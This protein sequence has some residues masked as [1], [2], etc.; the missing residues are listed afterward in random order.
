MALL[1]AQFV[2]AVQPAPVGT[3]IHDWPGQNIPTGWISVDGQAISRDDYADLFSAI[4]T[5]YGVGD[6]STTF[7]VP[8]KSMESDAAGR[9]SLPY[10]PMFSAS[11]T[12]GTPGKY[13]T[14]YAAITANVG[15]HFNTTTGIFTAPA[16]GY[17]FFVATGFKENGQPAPTE[18]VVRVNGV[19]YKRAYDETG[20][21]NYA[22]TPGTNGVF[23][24]AANDTVGI[25]QTY[26][27][28]HTGNN[29]HFSGWKVS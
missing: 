24:L 18:Y 23:G 9:V 25:Y 15:N 6:G 22:A 16:A 14:I 7:N 19:Y 29:M 5:T 3:I 17:Y 1:G 11:G 28:M 27:T 20:A 2:N 12:N 26:G 10:Q 13:W 4:G 8:K 21:G